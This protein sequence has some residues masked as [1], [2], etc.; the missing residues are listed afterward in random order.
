MM[1]CPAGN[2]LGER[3]PRG[4]PAP[5]PVLWPGTRRDKP[6]DLSGVGMGQVML[7][8]ILS[9]EVVAHADDITGEISCL[10]GLQ[11]R[12]GYPT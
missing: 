8:W 7:A 12:K 2:G 10:K 5:R 6:R 4:N 3:G 1:L 11:G 9:R